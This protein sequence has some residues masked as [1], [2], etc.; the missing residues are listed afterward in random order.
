[1]CET[2]L[3]LGSRWQII[4]IGTKRI[5]LAAVLVYC[6]AD[7]KLKAD[8]GWDGYK[9][10]RYPKWKKEFNKYLRILKKK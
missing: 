3:C 6:G 1:M 4:I 9:Y 5:D 10:F 7:L 8:N 2:K